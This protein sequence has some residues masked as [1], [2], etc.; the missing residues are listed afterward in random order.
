L[1]TAREEA[2]NLARLL[3]RLALGLALL[4][5][6]VVVLGRTFRP[7]LEG[8]GRGFV[9]R[10]GLFGMGLGTFIA[11]GFHVPIPPQ[12]YMLLGITS[13]VPATHTLAVIG[14]GSFAGG[15]VG[16]LLSRHLLCFEAV[17]RL[18]ERPQKLAEG[19]LARHGAW[20][21]VFLS[22]LPVAYSVLCYLSGL[23]GLKNRAFLVIALFRLP[24]LVAYYYLVELGWS[25]V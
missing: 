14:A 16:F 6:F 21:L 9:A 15:W 24:R 4:L 22:L 19:M 12:F 13:G 7:E 3:L 10:F 23:A 25:G 18:F 8:I 5:A 17:A 20:A 11:D 2:P 1:T